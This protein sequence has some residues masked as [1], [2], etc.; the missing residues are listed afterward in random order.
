MFHLVL[1][2]LKIIFVVSIFKFTWLVILELVADFRGLSIL[3]ADNSTTHCMALLLWGRKNDGATQNCF[4]HYVL[5]IP[6]SSKYRL[7]SDWL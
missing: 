5:H 1:V 7:W 2:P 4:F 6:S 3:T